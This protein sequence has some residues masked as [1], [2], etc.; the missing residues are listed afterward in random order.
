MKLRAVEFIETIIE[1][2]CSLGAS[3]IHIDPFSDR[4][5]VRFR[6]DGLLRHVC[7]IPPP[8]HPEVVAR[9][10]IL[11]GLRTDM[12]MMPQDGR[13]RHVVQNVSHAEC[14]IRISIMPTHYGENIVMR[15]LMS[16][17]DQASLAD[18][19][20]SSSDASHIE[21]ALACHHGLILV[22]GPTGSGKTTTL[23]A[24]LGML[25]KSES[26]IITLE[27]PIEY[28]LDGIRQVQ[29][30]HKY[31]VTFASGLRA[32]LR[33]DPDIIMV[34]EIRDTETARIAIHSALTGH[35]VLSTLHTNSACA[36]LPRLFDMG[37][38]PYLI[39]ATLSLVVGQR[40]V[41]K[42][43]NNREGKPVYK[44]RVGIYETLVVDDLVRSAIL[45]SSSIDVLQKIA[46]KNN[47]RTMQED[48]IEK[49][50]RG[51]TTRAELM[52]VLYE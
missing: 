39:A 16:R 8:T 24:L 26:S 2:A 43:V 44:G 9:I 15:I 18:L 28:T 33:Q 29:V 25:N 11:A 22:T 32:M 21:T 3:D 30:N 17:R 37:L 1:K 6:V 52:R 45:N 27:D 34:G 50:T 35:L 23:Y 13:F 51:I 41:R 7:D 48:G 5:V 47:M 42:T 36:T 38:E 40:L 46:V 10:K 14:D 19:G 12:H 49:V 4:S 20:L 31:G